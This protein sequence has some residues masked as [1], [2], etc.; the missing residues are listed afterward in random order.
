MLLHIHFVTLAAKLWKCKPWR[1]SDRSAIKFL[2][3]DVKI[4]VFDDVVIF[5]NILKFECDK[6]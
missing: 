2:F 5:Y 1:M 4:L 3:M 6:Q